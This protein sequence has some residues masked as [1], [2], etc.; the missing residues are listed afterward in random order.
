LIIFAAT[1]ATAFI[2]VLILWNLRPNLEGQPGLL[3]S[4]I[5]VAMALIVELAICIP[6]VYS[7][8]IRQS[9]RVVGPLRRIMRTLEAIGSGDFSKRLGLRPGDVL[10]DLA[11]AI[12]RMAENLQ[13]RHSKPTGS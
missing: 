5:G 2:A 7:L 13:K 11:R 3:A 8:G 6:M 4:L 9:H 12:N 10:E 1:I